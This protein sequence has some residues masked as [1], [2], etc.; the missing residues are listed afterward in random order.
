M[1]PVEEL[2]HEIDELTGALKKGT[3]AQSAAARAQSSERLMQLLRTLRDTP[4]ESDARA[5]KGLWR[6][7]KVA[8]GET[9][10][11]ARERLD[12]L[13]RAGKVE[14]AYRLGL[15]L[16]DSGP[17]HIAEA[18]KWLEESDRGAH[19]RAPFDLGL[20]YMRHRR[21]APPETRLEKAR[22]YFERAVQNSDDAEACAH[23]SIMYRHGLGADKNLE[24]AREYLHRALAKTDDG[25]SSPRAHATYG[26]ECMHA[27]Q[28]DKALHHLIFASRGGAPRGDAMLNAARL[29]LRGGASDEALERE[30]VREIEEAAY[31]LLGSAASMRKPP[32]GFDFQSPACYEL[33]RLQAIGTGCTQDVEAAFDNMHRAADQG[34][35]PAM[36]RIQDML[37]ERGMHEEVAAF[38]ARVNAAERDKAGDFAQ[39]DSDDYTE[40]SEAHVSFFNEVAELLDE[41]EYG[42][43]LNKIMSL[44]DWAEKNWA[45][46]HAK[47]I[48]RDAGIR[49]HC[50]VARRGLGQI[51]EA[52]RDFTQSAKDRDD[53]RHQSMCYS[54]MAECEEISGDFDASARYYF[55]GFLVSAHADMWIKHARAIFMHNPARQ[56]VALLKIEAFMKR[57]NTW[58]EETLRIK[59]P[60]DKEPIKTSVAYAE[61][62]WRLPADVELPDPDAV[63]RTQG[64]L[65]FYL[66]KH[67]KEEGRVERRV[68]YALSRGARWDSV[69]R[70]VAWLVE[71]VGMGGH[72]DLDAQKAFPHPLLAPGEGVTVLNAIRE[73]LGRSHAQSADIA[74]A[75]VKRIT[76]AP[77]LIQRSPRLAHSLAHLLWRCIVQAYYLDSKNPADFRKRVRA[78]LIPLVDNFLIGG[79]QESLRDWMFELVA[80]DKASVEYGLVADF[81]ESMREKYLDPYTGSFRDVSDR[82]RARGLNDLRELATRLLEPRAMLDHPAFGDLANDTAQYARQTLAQNIKRLLHVSVLPHGVRFHV[83]LE[84]PDDPDTLV[85]T[86]ARIDLTLLLARIISDEGPLHEVMSASKH[87]SVRGRWV[88]PDT[89]AM[90]FLCVESS[91][92]SELQEAAERALADIA[93]NHSLIIASAACR[94]NRNQDTIISLDAKLVPG[95]ALHSRLGEPWRE[96]LIS[97]IQE[98]SEHRLL[99][100]SYPTFFE[101]LRS[102]MPRLGVAAGATAVAQAER[103]TLIIHA[104]CD[105][106]HAFFAG[107]LLRTSQVDRSPIGALHDLKKALSLLRSNAVRHSLTEADLVDFRQRVG[108]LT[109]TAERLLKRTL[110][111]WRPDSFDLRAEFER[112][113]GLLTQVFGSSHNGVDILGMKEVKIK[114]PKEQ[115]LMAMRELLANAQSH[116]KGKPGTRR[117]PVIVEFQTDTV[118]IRNPRAHAVARDILST[119][120][121]M[122][123]ANGWLEACGMTLKQD[124]DGPGFAVRVSLGGETGAVGNA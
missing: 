111:G 73:G 24:K 7:C 92:Q 55:D 40:R 14:H 9:Q 46:P 4:H 105:R 59:F 37:A 57:D 100:I 67:A 75:V 108:A 74:V 91:K 113:A 102:Q 6:L 86:A 120:K 76:R 60:V 81:L 99:G 15:L 11:A 101:T 17:D 77:D 21:S 78:M 23:L 49:Y 68:L 94:R 118:V 71:N 115:V 114:A 28:F 13:A 61:L 32:N 26:L 48:A 35:L 69:R 64:Q 66:R 80:A 50:G 51:K 53:F 42:P 122:A 38:Q 36:R 72:A 62:L 82:L 20:I 18:L 79:D 1:N 87:I 22:R 88:G 104:V 56:R 65:L 29:L 93:E 34:F 27:G 44:Y 70:E 25:E 97:L 43:A 95:T 52:I 117:S 19:R 39:W 8:R 106:F 90:S 12:H 119:G 47:R 58:M 45:N 3:A 98:H 2:L 54:A 112:P 85:S 121:G 124:D 96:Y 63:Q 33:A 110:T 103:W 123:A 109:P 30:G 89:L 84:E 16:R 5:A 10:A 116:T 41:G 31:A 83:D 107:S